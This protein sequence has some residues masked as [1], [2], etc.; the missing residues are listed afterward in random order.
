MTIASRTLARQLLGLALGATLSLASSAEE[1]VDLQAKYA[2]ACS[3]PPPG[4]VQGSC[5]ARTGLEVDKS[6]YGLHKWITCLQEARHWGTGGMPDA[7]FFSELIPEWE[8]EIAVNLVALTPLLSKTDGKYLLIE[9][10][11]WERAR[12]RNVQKVQ[13]GPRQLGSMYRVSES[14]LA[15][16][17]PEQRAL[18]L[19][20][21]IEKLSPPQH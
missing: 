19:A 17:L 13:Q 7:I 14:L 8:K 15:L 16:G 12:E 5:E 11:T 1:T 3:R 18:E 10:R 21:R 9:Q 20:C 2:P 6:P 4:M